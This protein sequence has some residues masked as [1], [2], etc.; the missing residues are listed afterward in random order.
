MATKQRTAKVFMN[1][2]S[3]AVRLPADF[4]FPEG[5]GEVFVRKDAATGVLMLSATPLGTWED[6]L[7]LR[8][9]EP[10]PPD[11][12][13]SRPLNDALRPREPK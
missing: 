11:Y 12:M 4:R 3:Q 5:V 2:A 6:F 9:Q 7:Q 1:G 13:Q 10:A 8:A